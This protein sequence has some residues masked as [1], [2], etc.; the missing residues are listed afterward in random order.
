VLPQQFGVD[1]L[2]RAH[3]VRHQAAARV[4]ADHHDDGFTHGRMQAQ[5][6]RRGAHQREQGLLQ[7]W[8]PL[9]RALAPCAWP[10]DPVT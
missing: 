10:A 9:G 6:P 1:S 5:R 2:V 4:L 7:P 8:V 3:H